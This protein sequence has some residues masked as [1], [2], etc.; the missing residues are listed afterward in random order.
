[1]DLEKL[2]RILGGNPAVTYK[3]NEVLFFHRDMCNSIRVVSTGDVGK[4]KIERSLRKGIV[5]EETVLLEDIAHLVVEMAA[6]EITP[7]RNFLFPRG[8]DDAMAICTE[9]YHKEVAPVLIK[10]QQEEA[11]DLLRSA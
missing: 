6:Q 11:E 3:D 5:H 8:L 2:K 1:M 10:R 7:E 9:R 4:Y